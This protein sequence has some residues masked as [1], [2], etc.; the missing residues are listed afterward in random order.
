MGK[1]AKKMTILVA[2]DD[3]RIVRLMSRNLQLAGYQTLSARD[4][5]QSLEQIESKEPTLVLLDV[6][7]PGLNGFEV[8]KRIREFS[9]VPIIIVTAREQEEDRIRGLDLG[10]DDYLTKPF[11]MGELLARV[12]AVLRR[13][14]WDAIK[15]D[16]ESRP[17]ITVGD[18][19]INLVQQ[20]V[21]V[22]GRVVELTPTEYHVV[23]YLAQNIGRIVTPD[24]LLEHVWGEEYVSEH[25][26]LIVNI[27]RVRRK[28]EP[29]PAHPIYII[30]RK[31]IGYL[32]PSRPASGKA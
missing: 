22:Q 11:G 30:T 29:D 20:Q 15:S 21:S 17:Q 28:M 25:H 14:Q 2:D 4:G 5:Q 7:M 19:T 13:G 31:G 10:A 27:N 3:P 26:L 18:L 8:C 24:L 16:Q 12:R 6:R 23:A 9:T 1:P 32:M